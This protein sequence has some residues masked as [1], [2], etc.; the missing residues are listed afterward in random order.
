MIKIQT[1]LNELFNQV[2]LDLHPFEIDKLNFIRLDSQRPL[3]VRIIK[4]GKVIE[5][6]MTNVVPEEIK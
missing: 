4:D 3:P 5:K 6:S 1:P 2:L